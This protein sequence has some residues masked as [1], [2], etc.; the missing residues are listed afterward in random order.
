MLNESD[1]ERMRDRNLARIETFQHNGWPLGACNDITVLIAA[2]QELQEA[3]AGLSVQVA[4]LEP[5]RTNYE[6]AIANINEIL[7]S[8]RRR[9]QC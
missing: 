5:Y 7:D 4:L 8:A 6:L 2:Y 1:I 9:E 3:N